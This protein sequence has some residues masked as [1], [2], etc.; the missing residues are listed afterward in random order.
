[1]NSKNH[2]LITFFLSYIF[3]FSLSPPLLANES[4]SVFYISKSDN[5]NQVHYGIHLN[6]DCSPKGNNPVYPYWKLAN[7]KT[8]DLLDL[9]KPAFD[10]ASQSVSG[11]VVTL[12]INGLKNSGIDRPIILKTSRS[13]NNQCQTQAFI[14]INQT[15]RKLSHIHVNLASIIRLPGIDVAL[16]GKVK[17]LTLIDT[18]QM[19]ETIACI[20]NCEFG[21]Q[22]ED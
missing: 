4:S 21:I 6:A 8:E 7:G 1:M 22:F 19:K 16:G 12:E 10:L 2:Q 18:N 15:L 13:N 20:S 14:K 9:E 11:N 3:L 5:Q 17:S